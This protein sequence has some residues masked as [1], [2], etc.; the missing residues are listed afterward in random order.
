MLHPS[1]VS[2]ISMHVLSDSQRSPCEV[3]ENY[4]WV[5]NRYCAMK[6]VLE[7]ATEFLSSND[8]F[9]R[10]LT[11]ASDLLWQNSLLNIINIYCFYFYITQLNLDLIY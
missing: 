1:L 10:K 2:Q 7:E 11:F 4:C 5:K 3:G 9:S 6:L 8:L